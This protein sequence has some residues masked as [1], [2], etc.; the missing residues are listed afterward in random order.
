MGT[1]RP[2][3]VQSKMLTMLLAPKSQ[4]ITSRSEITRK[5]NSGLRTLVY[6][7]AKDVFVPSNHIS[8]PPFPDGR[9]APLSG[10]LPPSATVW[11][12]PAPHAH[13]AMPQYAQRTNAHT[14]LNAGCNFDVDFLMAAYSRESKQVAA[15][16]QRQALF[17][18]KGVL[19]RRAKNVVLTGIVLRA[20]CFYGM[21]IEPPLPYLGVPK[22]TAKNEVASA[23]QRQRIGGEHMDQ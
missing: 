4:Q 16:K 15:E 20:I 12:V 19:C 3:S 17:I 14:S 9:G 1:I 6:A 11:I 10:A 8:E 21:E 13:D 5:K 23:S 7:Y 18:A 2:N 22:N